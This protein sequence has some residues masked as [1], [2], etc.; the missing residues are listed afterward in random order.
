MET[1]YTRAS[2]S[3]SAMKQRTGFG[4]P[5]EF[6]YE[7]TLTQH[8]AKVSKDISHREFMLAANKLLMHPAIRQVLRETLGQGYE[9]KMMP[10]LRTLVNDRN[11]SAVQGLSDLSKAMAKLRSN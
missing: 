11:G 1:G 8:I 4:G 7:Q 2:T 6:N 10:W 5:L 9:E 3:R